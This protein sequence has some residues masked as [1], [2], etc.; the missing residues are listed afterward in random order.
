MK[1]YTPRL[2]GTVTKYVFVESPEMT[3]SD[4]AI[5]AYEI[6]QGV[7]IK[8]TC[9]GLQVTGKEEDV[10]RIIDSLRALDPTRIFVKDRGFPPGD[11]R[12]CRANL[13]GARPGYFG[14][15]FEMGLVRF[16]SRGLSALPSRKAEDIPRPP[17]PGK[18][19]RL[20]AARLK[21][22]IE[23]QES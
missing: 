23:S 15:E 5:R 8:E 7:M 14:H 6:S 9:F 20:D 11:P 17:A 13:G 19:E 3:P 2:T 10:N 18:G 4:L 22:I 1:M 16:I 21:E 12:R